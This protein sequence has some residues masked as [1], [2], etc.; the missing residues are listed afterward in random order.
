MQMV[1]MSSSK[2]EKKVKKSAEKDAQKK[3]KELMNFLFWRNKNK[4]RKGIV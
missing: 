2:G 4:R 1:W 3:K